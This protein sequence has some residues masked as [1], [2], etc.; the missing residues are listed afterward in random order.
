MLARSAGLPDAASV[1]AA[2]AHS[3]IYATALLA[4]GIA[5]WARRVRLRPPT[6][7]LTVAAVRSPLETEPTGTG[8]ST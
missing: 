3:L 2:F 8:R 5:V 6:S 1:G 4:I 7:V